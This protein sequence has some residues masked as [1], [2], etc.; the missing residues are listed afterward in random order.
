VQAEIDAMNGGDE[1]A[2]HQQRAEQ[3]LTRIKDGA[4]RYVRLVAAR[5]QL[6]GAIERHRMR[7]QGPLVEL[8]TGFFRRLTGDA[9]SGLEV[10]YDDSERRVLL[11][12]RAAGTSVGVEGMSTG[13]RDQLFLALRLAAIVH[14]IEGSEALPIIADDLLTDFDDARAAQAL[15]LLSELSA[16]VQVIFFTHHKHLLSLAEASLD[17]STYAVHRL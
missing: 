5:L 12:K 15:V 3:A 1:A 4:Q 16:K 2:H 10:D 9:F 13:T 11:G 14:Y 7:S 17:A 6:Q 8:A